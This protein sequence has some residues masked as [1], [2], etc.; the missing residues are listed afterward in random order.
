M[1]Q[2]DNLIN[3]KRLQKCIAFY[4]DD[5]QKGPDQLLFWLEN[6]LPKDDYSMG[7]SC[8][9]GQEHI[10]WMKYCDEVSKFESYSMGYFYKVWKRN[11]RVLDIVQ[12]VE[13]TWNIWRIFDGLLRTKLTI[14]RA[15]L[16]RSED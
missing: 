14:T 15:T 10:Y 7:C 13:W 16:L 9:K 11:R 6:D 8:R 5:A 4:T 12:F 3:S 2:I 1:N